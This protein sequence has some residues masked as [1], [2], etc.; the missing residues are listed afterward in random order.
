VHWWWCPQSVTPPKV[1][2]T[3]ASLAEAPMTRALV[4]RPGSKA[5]DGNPTDND[6]DLLNFTAVLS[7]IACR[8]RSQL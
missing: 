7:E 6:P 1:D 8:M 5:S 2:K 4:A 3:D